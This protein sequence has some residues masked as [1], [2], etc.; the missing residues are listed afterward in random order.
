MAY[1]GIDLGT[2]YC[3]VAYAERGVVTRVAVD[4]GSFVMPS[5]VML[6]DRLGD[7]PRCLTGT[8]AAN[9]YRDLCAEFG[10]T[11]PGVQLVRGSKRHVGVTRAASGPPWRFAG[12]SLHATDI[13][14]L[15]LRALAQQIE[16]NPALPPIDGV[17]VTH[18]QRFRNR[19]RRAVAQA[20]AI[21]G[22]Q[23]VGLVPEPDAAAYA[24]GL[25]PRLKGRNATFMVF[26]FGGGTLDVTV[27]RR[28]SGGGPDR[29]EALASYG[30]ELGGLAIDERVRDH[31]LGRYAEALGLFDLGLDTLSEAS[32][33]AL[34]G[35]AEGLKIQLNA[36]ASADTNPMARVAVR[37]VALQTVD[38]RSFNAAPLRMSLGE[39]SSLIHDV[40]E[41]AAH[42]ASEALGRAGLGWS[43][44]DE[45][46][47][48]G[49]SSWL[50]PVQQKLRALCEGA[51]AGALAGPAV[52]LFDDVDDPMN[53]ATAVASGAA[54]YAEQR[55]AEAPVM[56]YH[57][58]TPDALGVRARE[59]DP[60]RPGER[61][62]ALAVLVP[63]RTRVPFE[64]RRV[65]RKR[66]GAGV[67]PIE[68]LEGA[69][70]V[71]ASVLGRFDVALPADL[72]DGAPV[73]VVLDVARD[74]VLSLGVRDPASDR[75][76][77]VTLR[78]AEGLYADDEI[79]ARRQWLS[80]V[81]IDRR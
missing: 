41:R 34:L 23:V 21:A 71:E 7:A 42:C 47:M 1:Y 79:E 4:R 74:G 13:A 55:A 51:A 10:D 60:S 35:V 66:G 15:T 80:T 17:V 65:F 27:L 32:R 28:A 3:S 61:R 62:E 69:S 43:S 16:W 81:S 36:H 78:D 75:V 24:Y 50:Y 6:D 54:R 52:R 67:L 2:T 18:P 76:E 40:I 53:P 58:V 22:L 70:L 68:V 9:R 57:G 77:R 38:G 48:V 19:E 26:D 59:A 64:G 29:L 44:L 39:F 5:L 56:D 11:P 37:A 73:E 72:A 25:G 31:L 30:V 63:A 20:A 46:L 33:E 12:Q 14:A 45:V 49:G 8:F